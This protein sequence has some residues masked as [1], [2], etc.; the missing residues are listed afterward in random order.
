MGMVIPCVGLVSSPLRTQHWPTLTK[1]Q[2][3]PK[4]YAVPA[5][6]FDSVPNSTFLPMMWKLIWAFE[7]VCLCRFAHTLS[8]EGTQEMQ[9]KARLWLPG[10]CM[11]G[12]LAPAAH[13][14]PPAPGG[15][16]PPLEPHPPPTFPREVLPLKDPPVI[17]FPPHPRS[18]ISTKFQSTLSINPLLLQFAVEVNNSLYLTFPVQE[19]KFL[20]K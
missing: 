8:V 3:H 10:S 7:I 18:W 19:R 2:W 12:L 14:A 16:Q 11:G 5:Y 1:C 20:E 6:L 9:Q 17:D 13:V 15:Q 4:S